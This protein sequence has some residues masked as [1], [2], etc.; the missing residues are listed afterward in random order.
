MM[1]ALVSNRPLFITVLAAA[2]ILLATA[3]FFTWQRITAPPTPPTAT[4]GTIGLMLGGSQQP[5]GKSSQQS[6]DCFYHAYQRCAA[7]TLDVHIMGT[8]TGADSIYW[9]VKQG[10]SCHIIGVFTSYGLVSSANHTETDTCQGL[11]R[12]NGGLLFLNWNSGGN[13]FIP[14]ASQQ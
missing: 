12:K 10:N 9:P 3:G 1:R 5:S 2:I 6:E 7:M 8:D 13:S 14:P 4:C 11:I